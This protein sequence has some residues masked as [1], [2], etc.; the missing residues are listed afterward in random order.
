MKSGPP[1]K[2]SS[3]ES[4]AGGRPIARL[5][6]SAMSRFPTA[7][8]IFGL[9]AKHGVAAH[10]HYGANGK[11][12]NVYVDGKAVNGAGNG[13]EANPWD[14]VLSNAVDKKRSS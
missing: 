6:S 11:I 14:Q 9:A 13:A 10:I 4:F 7:G 8:S 3:P 12:D 5:M 2:P 1:A